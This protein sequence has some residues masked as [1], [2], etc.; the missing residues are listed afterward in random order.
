[1]RR[2][3]AFAIRIYHSRKQI[4]IPKK[5]CMH[6]FWELQMCF[7]VETLFGCGLRKKNYNLDALPNAT[8]I[9]TLFY[10]CF[11]LLDKL[12]PY[13]RQIH[14]NA[15][16]HVCDSIQLFRVILVG[17]VWNLSP[18]GSKWRFFFILFSIIF[19]CMSYSFEMPIPLNFEPIHLCVLHIRLNITLLKP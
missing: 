9:L 18:F 13:I 3:C 6:S 1:M 16:S 4:Y 17:F 12:T 19:C 10:R 7:V 15:M 5:K 14:I 11:L 2:L 8:N